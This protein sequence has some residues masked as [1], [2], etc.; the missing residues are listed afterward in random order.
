MLAVAALAAVGFFADRLNQG[1]ARDARQLLGGDAIVASDQPTPAAFTEQARTR[2]LQTVRTTGY[3]LRG[4][5]TLGQAA[6]DE[7]TPS[8]AA[9]A[10]GTVWV[11]PG[12]LESLQ[13]KVGDPLLL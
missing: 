6:T 3:P 12:L 13:L 9:P 10:P 5:L 8:N 7:G 4:Q 2:G 1:L 11:D